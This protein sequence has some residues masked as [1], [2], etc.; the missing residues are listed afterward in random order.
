MRTIITLWEGAFI[1]KPHENQAKFRIS[2][3]TVYVIT[4][5]DEITI[6]YDDVLITCHSESIENTLN[7]VRE[8]L[9]NVGTN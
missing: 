9:E 5:F 1:N 2:E 3:T 4:T 6:V 7:M 8:A